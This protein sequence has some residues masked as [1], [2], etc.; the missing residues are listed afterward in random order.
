MVGAVLA[1]VVAFQEDDPRDDIA[2]LAVRV[3][4]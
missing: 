1:D 3:P 2:L 4:A